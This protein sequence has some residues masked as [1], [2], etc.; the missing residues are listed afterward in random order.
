MPN[1]QLHCCDPPDRFLIHVDGDEEQRWKPRCQVW[2]F[3]GVGIAMWMCM[4]SISAAMMYS[5]SIVGYRVAPAERPFVIDQET[6]LP[7]PNPSYTIDSGITAQIR[8][9]CTPPASTDAFVPSGNAQLDEIR[10]LSAIALETN[11]TAFLNASNQPLTIDG[12]CSESPFADSYGDHY[13]DA[14]IA[15]GKSSPNTSPWPSQQWIIGA[16][17]VTT[18]SGVVILIVLAGTH[19]PLRYVDTCD[20]RWTRVMWVLFGTMISIALLLLWMGQFTSAPGTRCF[21]MQAWYD[22]PFAPLPSSL[23]LLNQYADTATARTMPTND[24]LTIMFIDAWTER[25]VGVSK[26]Q[27]STEAIVATIPYTWS[28]MA[29]AGIEH[30]RT[31]RG[32]VCLAMTILFV[33]WIG[34]ATGIWEWIGDASQEYWREHCGTQT[35]ND[36]CQQCCDECCGCGCGSR[37][38]RC[39]CCSSS[40][41]VRTAQVQPQ[42]S[43]ISMSSVRIHVL[44]SASAPAP[45]SAASNTPV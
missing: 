19:V 1:T 8:I 11:L 13:H 6:D 16:I 22:G 40:H 34:L 37:I 12:G 44:P 5:S 21:L 7:L 43:G 36:A 18:T 45:P 35:C 41:S 24:P 17:V 27:S 32:T 29:L 10:Q 20:Q 38:C 9:T 31:V 33:V 42:P 25:C 2:Y 39:C 28:P 14:S 23:A 30:T 15:D 4:L 3:R 26:S